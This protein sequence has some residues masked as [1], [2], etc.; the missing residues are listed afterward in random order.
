M[1]INPSGSSG[2]SG[3]DGMT[4]SLEDRILSARPMGMMAVL[5]SASG[6]ERYPAG[7]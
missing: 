5:L 1:Q 2:S 6:M 7:R 3:G 4:A